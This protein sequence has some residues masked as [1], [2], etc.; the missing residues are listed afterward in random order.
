MRLRA[1]A[2]DTARPLSRVLDDFLT[3]HFLE[4]DRAVGRLADSE[5]IRI[6]K[7]NNALR[8]AN[9]GELV[10]PDDCLALAITLLEREARTQAQLPDQED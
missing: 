2:E 7:A 4:E 8:A 10:A 9:A 5:T 3:S 6:A 1:I